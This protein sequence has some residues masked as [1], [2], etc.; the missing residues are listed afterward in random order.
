MI[1]HF[2]EVLEFVFHNVS[3]KP[4]AFSDHKKVANEGR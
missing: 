3:F 4:E 2:L 1:L